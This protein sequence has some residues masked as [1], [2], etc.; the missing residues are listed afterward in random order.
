M[1]P[2]Q[3]DPN[4]Q[5]NSLAD[6]TLEQAQLNALFAYEAQIADWNRARVAEYEAAWKVY[7]AA[8]DARPDAPSNVPA[9]VP[10]RA[11]AVARDE[12]GW[13]NVAISDK[14]VVAPHT[15]V[16][17]ATTA[18]GWFAAGIDVQPGVIGDPIA[19]FDAAN[20]TDTITRPNGKV[21]MRIQ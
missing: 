16:P 6:S 18:K 17:P 12:R 1:T 13:P 21:F 7:V 8:R 10:A 14:P 9:P 15:Y 20:I 5:F 4:H 3:A 2:I 11:E 19:A